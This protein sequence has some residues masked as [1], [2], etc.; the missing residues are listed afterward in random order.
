METLRIRVSHNQNS[1]AGRIITGMT[2]SLRCPSEVILKKLETLRKRV[3]ENQNSGA[4]WT[5]MGTTVRHMC[6][7]VDT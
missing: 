1:C 5:V 2:V 6:L 4:G 7:L 3:F